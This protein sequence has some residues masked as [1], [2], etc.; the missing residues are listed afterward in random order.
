MAGIKHAAK[1]QTMKIEKYEAPIRRGYGGIV[2][3]LRALKKDEAIRLKTAGEFQ[4]SQM[5][6]SR[7]S[8]ELGVKFGQ[9]TDG[10]DVLIFIKP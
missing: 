8:K 4:V 3:A 6:R 1:I 9:R 2:D 10:D 7:V 5:A